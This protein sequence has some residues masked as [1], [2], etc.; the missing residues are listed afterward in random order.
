[1]QA[2]KKTLMDFLWSDGGRMDVRNVAGRAF[3]NMDENLLYEVV[4]AKDR[5]LEIKSYDPNSERWNQQS[6]IKMDGHFSDRHVLPSE[7]RYY[8][9]GTVKTLLISEMGDN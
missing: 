5:E 3:Y 6:S 8:E 4:G 7:V 1:M 2:E 9:T